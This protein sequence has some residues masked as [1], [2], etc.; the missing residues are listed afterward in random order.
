LVRIEAGRVVLAT[1]VCRA[2]IFDMDG[3]VT[4]SVPAHRRAWKQTFDSFLRR[5]GDPVEFDEVA[6]Y[7]TF[8]DG[9]PRYDGV[10][11]FLDSR[12]VVLPE[13]APDDPPGAETVCG[14]GNQKNQQFLQTMAECGIDAYRSTLDLIDLL[15]SNGVGVALITSSRNS[16]QVLAAAGVDPGIFGHVVDGNESARIGLPGKP[17]PAIFLEAAARLGEEAR[18]CVVVEDAVSG[19]M[20][21]RAGDFGAVIGVDRGDSADVLTAAGADVVVADLDEVTVN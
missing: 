2:V 8:V 18:A 21:G 9:K 15:H 19:V 20:A 16:G 1:E 6:D 14:L 10:R 13:G 11:S 7:L 4:D 3:V 12:G 5:V 17:H